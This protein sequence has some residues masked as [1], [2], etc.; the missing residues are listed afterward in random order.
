[1]VSIWF[2]HLDNTWFIHLANI[3]FAYYFY[4]SLQDLFQ[5]KREIVPRAKTLLL[6][7]GKKGDLFALDGSF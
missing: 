3:W 7:V 6:G 5:R 2:V 4:T 1:M